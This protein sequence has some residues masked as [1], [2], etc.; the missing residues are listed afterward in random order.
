MSF[1][2]SEKLY[3]EGLKHLVGAVNSPVRAFK[4][5]GGNPLFI[6]KE[7]KAVKLLM[8]TVMSM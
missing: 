6:K 3:K 2:E 5:V 4:S 7:P 8:L 1:K